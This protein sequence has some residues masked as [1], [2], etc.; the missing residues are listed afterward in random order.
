M[1]KGAKVALFLAKEIA[2]QKQRQVK[3]A[4]KERERERQAKEDYLLQVRQYQS[5]LFESWQEREERWRQVFSGERLKTINWEDKLS[6]QPFPEPE[7]PETESLFRKATETVKERFRKRIGAGWIFSGLLLSL[8]SLAEN[9]NELLIF[10]LGSLASG[11]G[12]LSLYQRRKNNISEASRK[13]E[14]EAESLHHEYKAQRD[15]AYLKYEQKENERLTKIQALL[16]GELEAVEKTARRFLGTVEW[17]KGV[18]IDI[19]ALNSGAVEIIS[20]VPGLSIIDEE[21]ARWDE[22]KGIT[23]FSSKPPKEVVREYERLLAAVIL[24]AGNEIFRSCPTV[25]QIYSNVKTEKNHRT[26]GTAYEAYIL[27]C[28]LEREIFEEIDFTKVEYIEALENFRLIFSRRGTEIP[29]DIQPHRYREEVNH[30]ELAELITIDLDSLSGE[31]FED[32]TKD[33]VERMG[34]KAEKTK[35]SHDGGIDIWATSDHALAGGRFIIQCKR[36]KTT[37]PVDV[38]RD[39]Y[40]AVTREKADGGILLATS[41]ISNDC[42]KF[43]NEASHRI[44]IKLIAGSQLHSL[45]NEYGMAN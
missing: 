32:L 21:V 39:L 13:A 3:E 43:V 6:S 33:L 7:L 29:G 4:E 9:G 14:L 35:K 8:F 12:L 11:V 17:P 41:D 28:V 36:W 23:K 27:S 44:P 15:E 42:Y 25:T 34:L 5:G 38:V 45:L 1:G 16:Q 22:Q 2:K 24:R 26:K 40:G 37:I 10:G 18:T 19:Q 31:Q 20:L 30:G